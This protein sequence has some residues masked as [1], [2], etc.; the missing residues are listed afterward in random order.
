M[1]TPLRVGLMFALFLPSLACADPVPKVVPYRV[2]GTDFAVRAAPGLDTEG[3]SARNL[4]LWD[5]TNGWFAQVRVDPEQEGYTH[6]SYADW[7]LGELGR[8]YAFEPPAQIDSKVAGFPSRS[9][10]FTYLEATGA[11]YV[12]WHNTVEVPTGFVRILVVGPAERFA[13][14]TDLFRPLVESLHR[15][16]QAPRPE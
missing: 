1:R 6:T 5:S 4:K 7:A 9:G 8:L 2:D 15:V 10:R 14:N 11:Q 13:K 3:S 16:D 12:G